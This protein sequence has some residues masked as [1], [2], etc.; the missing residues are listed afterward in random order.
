MD[1]LI[2]YWD[3]N[4]SVK[5]K[6]WLPSFLRH[7]TYSDLLKHFNKSLSELDLSKMLQMS[8]DGPAVNWKFFDVLIN[9]VV[10]ECEL[11][12]LINIGNCSLHTVHGTLKTAVE[13]TTWR[14]KQTLKGVQQILHE[15]LARREDFESVTGTN[16]YPLFFWSIR[17]VERKSVADHA[18]ENWPSIYK[19]VGFWEK[20]PTSKQPKSKSFL[21]LQEA[22]KESVTLKLDSFSFI[23][24]LME[25]Y[26]HAYQ[27]N[28]QVILF[29]CND[30]EKISKNLLKLFIKP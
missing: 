18:I 12:Q 4:D 5:V 10:S 26:L 7:S 29:M 17:W 20:L 19:L 30:L 8:I 16:K 27:T 13:S 23:A 15:S 3:S 1:I 22:V 14:I 21:N 9:N 2:W 11:P 25:P 24:S 28:K 6:Y